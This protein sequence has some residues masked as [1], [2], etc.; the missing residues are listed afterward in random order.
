MDG[1]NTVAFMFS[2]VAW[3]CDDFQVDRLIKCM[4]KWETA[5]DQ[6][7]FGLQTFRGIVKLL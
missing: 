7:P 6:G 3:C 1:A 4:V 2:T 5:K